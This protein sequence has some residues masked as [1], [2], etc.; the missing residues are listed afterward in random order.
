MNVHNNP[1]FLH[2]IC[3]EFRICSCKNRANFDKISISSFS[4]LFSSTLRTAMDA[5]IVLSRRAVDAAMM[6]L[7]TAI[8]AVFLL[9]SLLFMLHIIAFCL[10]FLVTFYHFP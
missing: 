6:S 2:R 3:I 10:F 8:D 9:E 7:R 5:A 4:L 1:P